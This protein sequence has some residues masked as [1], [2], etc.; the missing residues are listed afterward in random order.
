MAFRRGTQ[1]A[2][3]T[4]AIMWGGHSCPPLAGFASA[5]GTRTG[6]SAPHQIYFAPLAVDERNPSNAGFFSRRSGKLLS[7]DVNP[8]QRT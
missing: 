8:G 2:F 3:N 5:V 1:E 6:V 4:S 7:Y